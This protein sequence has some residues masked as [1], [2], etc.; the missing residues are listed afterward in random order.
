MESLAA[1]LVPEG[2]E[3]SYVVDFVLYTFLPMVF[4]FR[5]R[6]VL[7]LCIVCLRD[8]SSAVGQQTK[9]TVLGWKSM[10]VK[11]TSNILFISFAFV[12]LL[13]IA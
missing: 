11:N 6:I 1:Q 8:R 4:N 5:V 2:I 10:K 9:E 12:H 13:T 7:N 3:E